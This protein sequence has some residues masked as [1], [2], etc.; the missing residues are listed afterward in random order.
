MQLHDT[1]VAISSPPGPAARGIVRLSGPESHRLAGIFFE[2]LQIKQP[3]QAFPTIIEG[4][5]RLDSG[6]LPASAWMFAAPKSYTRQDMVELHTLGSPG[7]LGLIVEA[8]IAAGARR[9][10]AGE[11]TA[12]AYLNG[13]LDLAQVHGVAALISAQSDGQRRAAARLLE[14]SLSK[15]A[16]AAREELADLLSLVE[17]ALDFADE[18][19]EFITPVDL[20][21]R[22][23]ALAAILQETLDVSMRTERWGRMPHVLL[24]GLPNA[25]K[26]SLLNRLSGMDRAI[27]TPIAGTTRDS[28]T[29]DLHLGGLSCVLIDTAGLTD[30]ESFTSASVPRAARLPVGARENSDNPDMLAIEATRSSFHNSD[31]LAWVIDATAP[32]ISWSSQFDAIR[33]LWPKSPDASLIVLNK[34][35]V[36]ASDQVLAWSAAICDAGFE[37]PAQVSAATGAG[38]NELSRRLAQMIMTGPDRDHE[39]PVAIAGEHHDALQR[40]LDALTRA[41]NV[42]QFSNDSLADADLVALELHAAAD[43]LGILVGRDVPDDLLGRVFARFCVGK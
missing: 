25:G 6:T 19:I 34:C 26:S 4:C 8:L 32:A 31:L 20:R 29:A 5:I 7:V 21:N 40:A 11:F 41:C 16:H 10:E 33:N 3:M 12:R 28:L 23:G 42:F 38:C 15:T 22:L 9:A 13:A 27:A 17:G 43:A 35:D 14:G 30:L 24:A 18:P 39:S 1:I 2:A 37:A 36:A